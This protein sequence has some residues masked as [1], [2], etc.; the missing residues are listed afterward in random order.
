LSLNRGIFYTFLTQVPTL[1]LYFISS[2]LITRLLGEDGR[3]AY[4]LLQNQTVLVAMLLSFNL[5]L[6]ITWFTAKD[7][8]DP[9]RMVR[10]CASLFVLNLLAVPILFLLLFRTE[11]L[12]ALF[13]PQQAN[14]WGYWL[15][16]V[17]TVLLSQFN[18]FIGS[19]LLALKRFR[20]LNR[21]A[22]L[23]AGLSA[24]GFSLLYWF[25]DRLV[26]GDALPAVLAV[27]LVFLV[28]LSCTWA[29]LYVRA[30]GI[31][32]VPIWSWAVLRPVLALV[33]VGYLGNFINLINY[34]FDVWVVGT[35]EGTAQLGLYAVA[36]GLGQLFFNVPEPFARVVQPYLYGQMGPELL[37]RFKFIMR[38]N[39]TVVAFLALLLGSLAPWIVPLLYGG[40]FMGSVVALQILLPGIL[41]ISGSKLIALLVVQGGHIRFN[42]YATSIAAV[43]TIALDLLLIPKFGISGAAIASSVSY[44]SLLVVPCLVVRFRMGIPVHD[45]FLLTPSDL[46]RLRSQLVARLR[47]AK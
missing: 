26:D 25:R 16:L 34:R 10:V 11:G 40:D 47:V 39:F 21:M 32:P 20:A 24:L 15:W 44:F 18:S 37:D 30:V 29:L 36:V 43:I 14:H 46:S 5:G 13:M 9:A 7:N 4:A 42:L 12:R 1:L 35:Y 22:L 17:L 23:H 3:G 31:V 33:M 19:L 41:C 38:L 6:G 45:L 8:G 2:T 27:S 28:L